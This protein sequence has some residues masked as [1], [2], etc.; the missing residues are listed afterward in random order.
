VPVA[1]R[2]VWS[3]LRRPLRCISQLP[4]FPG[5]LR[6]PG[7][8]AIRK[9]YSG[10]RDES[11][12]SRFEVYAKSFRD[13]V[14]VIE[15]RNHLGCIGD[16]LF[17]QSNRPE[18]LHVFSKRIRRLQSQFDREVAQGPIYF[19]QVSRG[20]IGLNLPYPFIIPDLGPE[21]VGMGLRSVMAPICPRHHHSQHFPLRP[22]QRRRPKHG[23]HV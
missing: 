20:V 13:A 4:A 9:H 19:G 21:V 1:A 3:V 15:K 11:S 14:N 16:C 23:G 22:R 2:R 8:H 12:H 7:L 5:S 17:A 6:Q 18:T 10:S